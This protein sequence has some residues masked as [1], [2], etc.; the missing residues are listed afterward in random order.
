MIGGLAACLVL[1]GWIPEGTPGPALETRFADCL[2]VAAL[3]L[4]EGIPP[5]I[6]T[7]LAWA[8]SRLN[9]DARGTSGEIGVLQVIPRWH[10]PGGRAEGCDSLAEGIEFLR[11]CLSRYRTIEAAVCHY[12]AGPGPCPESAVAWGRF[13]SRVVRVIRPV[14]LLAR[15]LDK[16]VSD[17]ARIALSP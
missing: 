17:R 16:V 3:A 12:N 15:S 8:E 9:R 14:V 2:R 5:E 11:T 10:C 4:D 1:V 6:A 7:S 13:V